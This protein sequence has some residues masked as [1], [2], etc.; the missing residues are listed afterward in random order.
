[1]GFLN[2]VPMVGFLSAL[3]KPLWNEHPLTMATA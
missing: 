3:G 1:M 2:E